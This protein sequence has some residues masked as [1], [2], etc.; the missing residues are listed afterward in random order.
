MDFVVGKFTANG[1]HHITKLTSPLLTR[2]PIDVRNDDEDDT[3]LA[4]L[5]AISLGFRG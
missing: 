2:G 4:D 1:L 3:I 5:H